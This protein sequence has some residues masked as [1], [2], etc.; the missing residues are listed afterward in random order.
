MRK[1][2]AR[3]DL[4]SESRGVYNFVQKASIDFRIPKTNGDL[5]P[6]FGLP[7]AALCR[8]GKTLEVI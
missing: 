4:L 8:K 1:S 3:V 5:I 2:K 7:Q 6:E